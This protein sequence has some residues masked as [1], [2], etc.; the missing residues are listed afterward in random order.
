MLWLSERHDLFAFNRQKG[1]TVLIGVVAVALAI[2]AMAIWFT[3]A[4]LVRWRFQFSMRSLFFLVVAVAMMCGWVATEE[5]AAKR[6]REA[7][8]A[9]GG[10]EAGA[11]GDPYMDLTAGWCVVVYDYQV[12]ARGEPTFKSNPAPAWLRRI[13]GDD[14]FASVVA[15]TAGVRTLSDADMARLEAFPR[16]Q[17]LCISG[18]PCYIHDGPLRSCNLTTLDPH[19]SS[20]RNGKASGLVR[21]AAHDLWVGFPT[22][23]T[24][25]GLKHLQYLT[26]LEFLEIGDPLVTDAG[27]KYVQGLTDLQVLDA[28]RA[29]ITDAGLRYLKRLKRLEI[30][31]IDGTKVTDAGLRYLKPLE[32]LKDLNLSNTW[33]GDEGV[34]QLTFLTGLES[35][36]LS[37]TRVGDRGLR[38]LTALRGLQVLSLQSTSVTSAGMEEARRAL[39]KCTFW[40]DTGYTL[41]KR[42]ENNSNSGYDIYP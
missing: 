4:L 35:L 11:E 36:D 12:D 27:L 16:L 40:S 20:L 3:F 22:R 34:E 23:V 13:F 14:F 26:K 6:Q 37:H 21:A 25:T 7:A 42:P 15:V 30:V 17:A 38:K 32:R 29:S 19:W 10:R 31:W 9:I 41:K 24:D 8:R 39:P 18:G 33:V 5:Q 1:W 2:L 28:G